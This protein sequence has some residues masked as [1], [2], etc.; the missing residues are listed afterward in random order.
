[1]KNKWFSKYPFS[2]RYNNHFSFISTIDRPLLLEDIRFIHDPH[3]MD[4][5]WI[6]DFS[7]SSETFTYSADESLLDVYEEL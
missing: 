1:M 4:G 6:P 7:L 3:S 2:F 5:Q